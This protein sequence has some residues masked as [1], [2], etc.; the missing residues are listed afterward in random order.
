MGVED[1]EVYPAAEN[2]TNMAANSGLL[3]PC[4]PMDST[5]GDVEGISCVVVQSENAF[6]RQNGEAGGVEVGAPV[7]PVGVS[8]VAKSPIA[9]RLL[10][11]PR[12]PCPK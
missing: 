4:Q 1:I 12:V 8:G 2:E 7:Q 6:P 11:S 3:P 9:V 5:V 10:A